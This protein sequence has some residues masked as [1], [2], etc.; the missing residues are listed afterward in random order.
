MQ[1]SSC[2]LWDAHCHLQ[3]ARIP[4][5]EVE[6]V[7]AEAREQGVCRL[8]VN[9]CW[10]EDWQRVLQLAAANAGVVLPQLGLHPWWVARRSAGWLQQLRRLLEENLGAG[11]GEVRETRQ[12]RV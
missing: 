3:D 1:A 5:S 4:A 10:Q 8:A 6:A 9:G 12:Q 2:E 11:V 7:L